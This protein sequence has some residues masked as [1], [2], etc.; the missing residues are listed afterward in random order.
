MGNLVNR[1]LTMIQR[2]RNGVVPQ[3][4]DEALRAVAEKTVSAYWEGMGRLDFVGALEALW[5]F[6]VRSNQYVEET[7]PWKL[8]KDPANA[9][10]LDGVLYNLAESARLISLLVTP[11]MPTIAQQIRAQLGVADKVQVFADEIAW[12]R[13]ATGTKIGQI[14]PLFPK[15]T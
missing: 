6:V 14:A 5:D 8:A 15:R 1:T 3:S 4:N 2:Y 9:R 11:F 12:G 10:Q 7:A 13:L